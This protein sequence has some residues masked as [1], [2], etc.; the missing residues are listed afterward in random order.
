MTGREKPEAGMASLLF[1]RV[2]M[3]PLRFSASGFLINL[4]DPEDERNS[5][6]IHSC[7]N[8]QR[9]YL[10]NPPVLMPDANC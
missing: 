4:S 3:K 2:R 6:E 5:S 10:Q 9:S 7:A 8:R 1:V